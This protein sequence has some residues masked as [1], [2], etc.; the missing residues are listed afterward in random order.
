MILDFF[1]FEVERDK[2]RRRKKI[3]C[4]AQNLTQG[5]ISQP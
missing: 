2:G 3:L 4:L 5:S 1:F